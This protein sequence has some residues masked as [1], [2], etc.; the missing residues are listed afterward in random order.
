MGL[1]VGDRFRVFRSLGQLTDPA[2]GLSLGQRKTEVGSIE[3]ME[4]QEK[5]AVCMSIG[6]APLQR[7]DLVLSN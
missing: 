4:I 5:V 2:T 6:E 3:V 1:R 7:G